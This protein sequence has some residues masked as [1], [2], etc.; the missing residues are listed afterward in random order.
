MLERIKKL[1]GVK[2]IPDEVTYLYKDAKNE[3][4]ALYLLKE[5]RRRDEGRLRQVLD[6]TEILDKFE[7]ELL[8]EGKREGS[9]NKKLVL[10]RKIKQIR[11]RINEINNK[12]NI[13]N[14]RI[15]I[16]TEHVQPLETILDLQEEE[17]PDQIAMEDLAVKAKEKLMELEM[18]KELAEGMETSMESK[19][20]DEEERAILAEFERGADLE[21]E[22]EEISPEKPKLIKRK[23]KKEKEKGELLEE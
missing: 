15:K 3:W 1:L 17:L 7:G 18:A 10:A 12:V 6:D 8:E 11:W 23:E 2:S 4:E 20:A 14:H 5:A 13:Y 9:E 21:L 16:F 22:E 19:V